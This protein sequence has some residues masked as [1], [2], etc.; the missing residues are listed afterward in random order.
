MDVPRANSRMDR[1]QDSCTAEQLWWHLES[2][3]QESSSQDR[4]G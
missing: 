3:S 1:P 4:M 2:V